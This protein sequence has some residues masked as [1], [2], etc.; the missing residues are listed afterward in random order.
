MSAAAASV[1]I[2]ESV[3]VIGPP[4]TELV[5][6]LARPA[7][8]R[9]AKAV[10]VVIVVGGPQT[11]VGSHRQFVLM[12]RAL[13]RAGY[14]CLRFDYAGMGDS[15]GPRPD[16]ERAGPDIRRACDAL[17]TAAPGCTRLALWGLCDGATAALFHA[18]TD[19]R[20]AAVVAANPW[21]RSDA[22]RSAALVVDHYGSRL[23]SAEFWK[24]LFSGRI[25]V[26][27]AAR[28]AFGHLMRARS[29]PPASNGALAGE[30]LPARLARALA[31]PREAVR[32]QLSGRDL[33]ATEFEMAMGK[34][35]ILQRTSATTLRLEEA[36]HTFSAPVNWQ[37]AI[38]DTVSTLAR[39]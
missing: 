26:L 19:E 4:G 1:D 12:A 7:E 37:T 38:D 29:R 35:G 10:G 3:V 30:G 13:A 21:A 2:D 34:T 14:P 5:G 22:T 16:F 20:I 36:D 23:R 18:A 11:R 17:M 32:L 15:P 28:E 25:D 39:L 33:T 24:K 8:E 6:V 9:A 31:A 27:G